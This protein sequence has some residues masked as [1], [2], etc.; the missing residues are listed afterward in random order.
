MEASHRQP[1]MLEGLSRFLVQHERCGAGFDV[2]HPAGLG[3]GR[4]SI[5]C[6][7]CGA[8]HEYTTATIGLEAEQP[9]APAAERAEAAPERR[10]IPPRPAPYPD[11]ESES[12]ELPEPREAAAPRGERVPEALPAASADVDAP[13]EPRSRAEGRESEDRDLWSSP[14]TTVALLAVA[15]IALVIAVIALVSDGNK[16]DQNA[17][18]PTQ[19]PPASSA[20]SPQPPAPAAPS[21]TVTLRTSLFSVELPNGWSRRSAGGSLLLEPH[22]SGRANVQIYYQA[23]P[24][25]SE[26]VMGRKTARFLRREV[27]GASLYPQRT[28][29]DGQSAQ[30]YTARGPGETAIAVNVLR[31]PYR[32]L[33]VRR[34]FAGA[35]PHVSL[36]AGR[37]VRSFR[38]N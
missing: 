18:S 13:G 4:V 29:I 21:P 12:L 17:A 1:G 9:A 32:Y 36:A 31:G 2:A 26:S 35:K 34:I 16:S 22:G 24:T 38:L 27:P 5:T 33:L 15:A 25:L 20:P 11:A 8:R 19:P 37:I 28:D 3:S 23:S 30:E 14:R 7:G 10:R 6:R